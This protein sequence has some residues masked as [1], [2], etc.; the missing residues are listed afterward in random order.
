[1][2]RENLEQQLGKIKK[3]FLVNPQ[4]KSIVREITLLMDRVLDSAYTMA[5]KALRSNGNK[6][7][8]LATGGFARR[9]LH[10]YS[11]I[12]IIILFENSLQAGDE[13]FLK[14]LLHPLWD[15]GLNVGH[16]V[17]QLKDYR[18]DQRNLELATALLDIRLLSGSSKIFSQFRQKELRGFLTRQK[19]EFLKTLLAAQQDRHKRF[20]ETIYQLEPDIKEAPGGLRDFHVARW[21]GRI[22]YGIETNTEFIKHD[23]LSARELRQVQESQQFLLLLRTYL[24]VL[25]GRNKNVLS[26]EF[27]EEM[28]RRLGYKGITESE[29]VEALMKDY[30]LRAKVIHGFGESMIRRAFPP[31]QKMSRAS[32]S[33]WSTT[34]VRRGALDFADESII[35]DHPANVLKLFYRSAKYQIPISENAL[36]QVKK[37]LDLIDENVRSSAEI[38]DLFL[39]LLRQQRGI[40]QALFLMHEIGLLGRIFPEFDRIRCHVIQDFFHKYTVDEHSLLTIK[41]LED[42]Y[43]ARKP[44][45]RRFG[46]ILK[47]LARPELLLFSM[48]FHDVGKAD[49]GNHCEQSIVAVNRI[50]RR[51]DLPEE[52]ADKIRFLI[53]SHLE[54]SNVFQ[55]RD[56]TDDMVVKRFA[57]FIGTQENLRMLCLVTYA[58]IKAVSPEALTTWKE[59]VLWQLY[60]EADAQLT[61]AFADDR[62]GTSQDQGLLE[63]VS[64][65]VSDHEARSRLRDFLEGFPR[66]YLKFTPKQKVADHFKLA[67]RLHSTEDFVLKLNRRQSRYELSLMAFDRPFLFAKLTGVLSYFGMNILRGQAFANRQGIILD[68][69]EFEDRF[70]TFKLNRSE[71]ERFRE[72]LQRVLLNQEDLT[73]LLRKRE[74]SILYQPKNRGSIATFIAFDDHSSEKYSIMEIVTQDRFGLLYA[75]ARTIS[76]NG[77]NIDVALIST[78]GHKAI[79]VFYLTQEGRKLSVEAQ[80]ELRASMKEGLDCVAA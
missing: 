66:R 31:A 33:S 34:V 16:H 35:S 46:E 51:I 80:Q 21:I 71:I 63:G 41:N 29:T 56:I 57:D 77:C 60:V 2:T 24:H 59:D 53:S 11:D 37:H 13:E 75:I 26:H 48:L 38:R 10:P 8:L 6:N 50:A 45:E 39:K 42:L 65:H 47:G 61:R 12:D 54:M 72:T 15:L 28:A 78:E 62:W 64:E 67:E 5:R 43:H 74:S 25:S 4:G 55:R 22:L 23:L 14:H 20:N 18:F 19:R 40:Y 9:E 68:V 70:Q 69:I 3:D 73:Q 36:D 30:F 52:D 58:D 49:P 32:H 44:R 1:M 27:Q 76:Q 79:D 17:L 7:A